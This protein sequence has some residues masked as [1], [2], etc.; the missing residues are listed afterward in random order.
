MFSLAFID[1]LR[2]R[3]AAAVDGF[4][5]ARALAEEAGWLDGVA[6]AYNNLA[7]VRLEQGD[8]RGAAEH[9]RAALRIHRANGNEH[10]EATMM[11]NLG[12]MCWSLATCTKPNS[13]CARRWS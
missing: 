11:G 1:R 7:A 6:A 3:F 4:E 10:G 9:L 8:I 12:A 13:T 2:S 5:T